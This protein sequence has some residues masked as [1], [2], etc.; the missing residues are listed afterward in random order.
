MPWPAAPSTY[1][2]LVG[3]E[4]ES[5]LFT[6]TSS[7]EGSSYR[8]HQDRLHGYLL[9]R[10][11]PIHLWLIRIWLVPAYRFRTLSWLLISRDWCF[12]IEGWLD[13]RTDSFCVLVDWEQLSPK[14]RA[15]HGPR[16]ER[17]RAVMQR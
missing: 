13:Q 8:P 7:S 14:Y 4:A 10:R 12:S 15:E 5:V 1:S 6:I 3:P 17:H 9:R 2:T 11:L 16:W